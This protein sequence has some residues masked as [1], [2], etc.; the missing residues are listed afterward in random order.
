MTV[1]GGTEQLFAT[2][3]SGLKFS[4]GSNRAR[5]MNFD[6]TQKRQH[7]QKLRV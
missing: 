3:Q 4:M 5:V 2:G 7:R 6:F 1:D